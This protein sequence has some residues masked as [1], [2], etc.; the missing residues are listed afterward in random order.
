MK[1]LNKKELAKYQLRYNHYLS[2]GKRVHILK[3]G[4]LIKDKHGTLYIVSQVVRSP[5]PGEYPRIV[6]EVK[7][8]E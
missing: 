3:E 7:K 8:D 2:W 6:L 5:I 4:T 1:A